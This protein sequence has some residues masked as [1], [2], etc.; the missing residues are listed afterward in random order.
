MFSGG[1][2]S[3]SAAWVGKQALI[4]SAMQGSYSTL[5][6]V[7]GRAA[8]QLLPHT[9]AVARSQANQRRQ[10]M[11]QRWHQQQQEQLSRPSTAPAGR[12]VDAAANQAGSCASNGIPSDESQESHA[13]PASDS[14]M[15]GNFQQQSMQR[16]QQQQQLAISRPPTASAA[17]ASCTGG[18]TPR[19]VPRNCRPGTAGTTGVAGQAQDGVQRLQ[20]QCLPQSAQRSGAGKAEG[21]ATML[22]PT[23]NE[24]LT[25][26]AAWVRN[27][28]EAVGNTKLLT[29]LVAAHQ[30]TVAGSSSSSSGCESVDCFYL[31][32]DGLADDAAACLDWVQQQAEAGQPLRP[33]HTVG[34]LC[35]QCGR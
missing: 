24:H 6:Q 33:V 17:A 20:Q 4:A 25:D 3:F 11:Q 7:G 5:R 1:C 19:P 35:L 16:W 34:E 23:D 18:E 8:G 21:Y 27:W 26:A 15:N 32:S 2:W 22:Q 12:F 10:Q 14:T 28:P 29:A 9:T 31:F 30:Y 13:Q